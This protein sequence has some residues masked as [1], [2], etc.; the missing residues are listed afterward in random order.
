MTDIQRKLG[1]VTDIC[2]KLGDLMDIQRKLGG[3]TDFWKKLGS[4]MNRRT[5]ASTHRRKK[6]NNIVFHYCGTQK[7]AM[8][9]K[10]CIIPVRKWPNF[11]KGLK[12]QGQILGYSSCVRVG[13]S[14]A[15]E[16]H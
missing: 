16:G 11:H 5:R 9:I 15:R 2:R 8:N 12:K 10:K 6:S 14:S 7:L 4:M 3:V 1:G 13:R